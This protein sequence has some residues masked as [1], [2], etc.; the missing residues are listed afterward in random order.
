[1]PR[2][3]RRGP[4]TECWSSY[5]RPGKTMTTSD[6]RYGRVRAVRLPHVLT[7]ELDKGAALVGGYSKA[8]EM[9]ATEQDL[10]RGWFLE[11]RGEIRHQRDTRITFRL[12]AR[13]ERALR[14]WGGRRPLSKIVGHLIIYSFT[15]GLGAQLPAILSSLPVPHAQ[16]PQ[17]RGGRASA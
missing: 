11:H 1:M 17:N 13:T 14:A 12:S 8:I 10:P 7:D 9:L 16:S 4:K 6:L 3:S 15:E 2:F 5:S